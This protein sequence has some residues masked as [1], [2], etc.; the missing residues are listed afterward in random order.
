M[1]RLLELDLVTRE[2]PFG[3]DEKDSKHS[4]YRI[5]DPFLRFWYGLVAPQAEHGSWAGGSARGLTLTA[6]SAGAAEWG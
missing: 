1:Q 4:L 5:G 6:L 2:K 3:A